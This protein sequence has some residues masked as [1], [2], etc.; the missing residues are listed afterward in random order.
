MRCNVWHVLFSFFSGSSLKGVKVK[1]HEASP[2]T[3]LAIRRAT[4]DDIVPIV[5]LI[6]RA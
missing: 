3:D 4:V 1:L 6:V 5:V 2:P